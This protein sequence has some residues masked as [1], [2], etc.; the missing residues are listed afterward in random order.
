MSAILN[1]I[2]EYLVS[3][4]PNEDKEKLV[5]WYDSASVNISMGI[6]EYAHRNQKQLNGKPYFEHCYD[7][8]ALYRHFVG[9]KLDDPYCIDSDLMN[10]LGIP[11]EGAQEVC[12]LHDVLEDTDVTM[13][14]IETVFTELGLKT[15]FEVWIKYPLQQITHDKLKDYDE[16]LGEVLKSKTASIVKMADLVSNL[17]LTR[18]PIFG[19]IEMQ[20]ALKYIKCFAMINI[21]HKFL[22]N[23]I[24]Y[25]KRFEEG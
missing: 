17:N 8:L 7:C 14:D 25:K 18:L 11:Y 13:D 23:V 19:D 5:A 12:L 16:Y 2:H 6:A 22:E 1:K 10:E 3:M 4:H 20:R 21:V 15:H 9:I 24:E